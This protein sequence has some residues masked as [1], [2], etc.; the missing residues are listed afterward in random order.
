MAAIPITING[1]V[2][3]LYG[4]TITGPIKIVGEAMISGLHVGGGPLPGGPD[5]G[6]P[7]PPLSIW[8]GAIDPYPGHPLPEPPGKPPEVTDPPVTWK[9]VWHPTEGWIVVG[10]INPD[11]EHPVPST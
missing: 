10:L 1:V 9:A 6:P 4:R 11:I 3:D 2:C 5:N 7:R 8:G